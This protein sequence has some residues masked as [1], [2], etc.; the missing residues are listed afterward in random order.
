MF[1]IIEIPLKRLHI[2]LLLIELIIQLTER[3][4]FYY[5]KYNK[6]IVQKYGLQIENTRRQLMLQNVTTNY[7]KI[8]KVFEWNSQSNRMH[9]KIKNYIYEFELCS[10]NKFRC[11]DCKNTNKK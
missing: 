3:N 7:P 5:F 2:F 8:K 9:I 6:L 11:V 4:L 1:D 10:D